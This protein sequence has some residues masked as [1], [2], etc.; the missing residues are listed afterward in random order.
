MEVCIHCRQNKGYLHRRGLCQTCFGKKQ[1]RFRYP[2]L[3]QP[4][5][6][7]TE[8]EVEQTIKEQME[9]LPP[10]WHED[11]EKQTRRQGKWWLED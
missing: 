11:V 9:N 2:K 5:R 6:E 8:E 4:D 7:P 3:G 1:I 10:W